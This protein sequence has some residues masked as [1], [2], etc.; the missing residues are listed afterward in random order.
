MIEL[1][2]VLVEWILLDFIW[3]QW[4]VEWI[5]RWLSERLNEFLYWL[6]GFCWV[7]YS[8]SGWL[9]GF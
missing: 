7:L 8:F 1:I 6:S 9:N 3:F 4:V 5:L 2:F